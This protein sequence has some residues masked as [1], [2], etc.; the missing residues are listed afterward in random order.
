MLE[1]L[2]LRAYFQFEFP[3]HYLDTPVLDGH[4][5]KWSEGHLLPPL[6]VLEEH[7]THDAEPIADV[8]AGWNED[9]L[10][11]GFDVPDRPGKL[12]G[13]SKDWWKHDG[14]RIC[15][16]TRDTRDLKRATRFCHLFYALPVGGGADKKSP[17][18]GQQRMSRSK[19]P[20][21]SV[22]TRRIRVATNIQRGQWYLEVLLPGSCLN[23]WD[24]AEHPRIGLYYKLKD[25]RLG[26]QQFAAEDELGWDVDPSLWPTAILTRP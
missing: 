15:V 17:I 8:Y 26:T 1:T 23:G 20:P 7:D 12:S 25:L 19:E 18:V 13:D 14:V 21:P 3:L 6:V 11:F 10:I 5:K 22:D 9:G 24:P 16:D 4:V 2:P